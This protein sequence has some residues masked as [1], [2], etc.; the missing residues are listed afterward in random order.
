MI[1]PV[2]GSGSCPA[3]TARVPKPWGVESLCMAPNLLRCG[4]AFTGDVASAE[5]ASNAAVRTVITGD[6][7]RRVAAV[8]VVPP[9]GGTN[10]SISHAPPRTGSDVVFRLKA[11]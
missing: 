11:E 3:W 8:F 4:G 9:S 7:V 5:P 2:A 10:G 6:A 1:A